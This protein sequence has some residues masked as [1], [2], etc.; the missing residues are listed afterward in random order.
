M[1]GALRQAAAHAT[2]HC[3]DRPSWCCLLSARTGDAVQCAA[4]LMCR[5]P[6]QR[7]AT[8]APLSN[9]LPGLGLLG[10]FPTT[11]SCVKRA[12][13]AVPKLEI[14]LFCHSLTEGSATHS[15]DA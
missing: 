14:K 11:G 5:T 8:I 15:Y 10:R 6:W 9:N 4:R 1:S 7:A 13:L 3:G 2:A 12:D